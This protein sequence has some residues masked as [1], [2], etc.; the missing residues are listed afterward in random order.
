MTSSGVEGFERLVLDTSAYS[1]L[2]HGHETVLD[3][4]AAAGIVL[5]PMIVLGELEAAYELGTRHRENRLM[6]EEFLD[7]PFVSTLPLTRSVTRRYG[8]LFAQL[9]T[10]GTPIPVNDVWIAAT[11]I[12]AGG[13]LLTL[14][15]DFQSIGSLDCTVLAVQ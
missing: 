9:R 7:E 2:R 6:L 3:Y 8:S 15:A 11:T 14:D 1:H 4:V 13:H 10:A 5:F 12:D